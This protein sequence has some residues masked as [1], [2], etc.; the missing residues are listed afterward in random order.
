VPT[1]VTTSSIT[2]VSGS[3]SAVTDVSKS[4]ATIHV[5]SVALKDCPD[6]TRAKTAQEAMK[7]PT[8]AG[9]AI[10]CA[11]RPIA[12]PTIMLMSAPASG[13]AGINQTVDTA[14]I[15]RRVLG[16]SSNAVV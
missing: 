8:S 12:R 6:A 4:P 1:P 16:V 2:P 14:S 11:R 10:Q 13:K 7:E 3:T 9:T 5:K 15:Y